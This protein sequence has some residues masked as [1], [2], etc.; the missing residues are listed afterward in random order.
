MDV[1]ISGN[2]AY[3]AD[4][5]S[6]FGNTSGLQVIEQCRF[7]KD[8]S[9][10]DSSTIMATVPAGYHPGTYNLYVANPDGGY[11]MLRNTFTIEEDYSTQMSADR[12]CQPK[13]IFDTSAGNLEDI[14]VAGT[15]PVPAGTYTFYLTRDKDQWLNG[16]VI[17]SAG[18]V[19]SRLINIDSSGQFCGLLWTPPV[20]DNN[21]YDIILDV[22][23]NGYF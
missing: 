1:A 2:L 17:C 12:D 21:N 11:T 16:D 18:C 6:G 22:N 20:G 10:V 15:I 8:I 13:D 7:L 3:V 19:A 23:G 14:Y 5:R 4:N 9:F